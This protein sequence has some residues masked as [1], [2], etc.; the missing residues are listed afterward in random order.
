[1]PLSYVRNPA[2]THAGGIVYRG[3][4]APEILL[5]RARPAPHDWVLPKGHIE[6]GETPHDCARR[7]I[8]E[9]AGVEAEPLAFLADDAFTTPDGKSVHSAFFL[10]A[11]VRAVS[12]AE[13]REV[14][15]CAFDEALSLVHF[16]GARRIIMAAQRELGRINRST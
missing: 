13:D 14:R 7:E 6:K 12:A 9:E 10:L 15:W 16:A 1:M 3:P 4:G 11:F 8:R 5:V 2:W